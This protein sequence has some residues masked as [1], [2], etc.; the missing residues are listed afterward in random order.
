MVH[1]IALDSLLTSKHELQGQQSQGKSDEE[2]TSKAV[3]A[4]I[5]I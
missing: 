4:R 3:L 2:H 5:A 1:A